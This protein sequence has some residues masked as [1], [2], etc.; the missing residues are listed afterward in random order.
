ME[1]HS[2][3]REFCNRLQFPHIIDPLFTS[4][5]SAAAIQHKHLDRPS[6]KMPLP[7][8]TA[9]QP[10]IPIAA[11]PQRLAPRPILGTARGTRIGAPRGVIVARVVI[12]VYRVVAY[13]RSFEVR[14]ADEVGDASV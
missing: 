10:Y 1:T 2:L 9:L 7:L 11:I 3:L 5:A 14:I 12:Q 13:K 4:A 6:L 8:Y